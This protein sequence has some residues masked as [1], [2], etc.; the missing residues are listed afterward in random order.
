MDEHC[1]TPTYSFSEQMDS[2]STN[3]LAGSQ[4]ESHGSTLADVPLPYSNKTP[5]C[6]YTEDTKVKILTM[7]LEPDEQH[8]LP[9]LQHIQL[10]GTHGSVV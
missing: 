5:V 10:T 9:F 2:T 1:E 4:S 8:T 3:V 7:A 6:L